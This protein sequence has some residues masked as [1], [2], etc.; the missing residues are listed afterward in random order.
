V[1]ANPVLTNG[2][3]LFN[4]QAVMS[5]QGM[6]RWNAITAEIG[7]W[8]MYAAQ[9]GT[10]I[11]K[12]LVDGIASASSSLK[13]QKR[14]KKAKAPG[15]PVPAPGAPVPAPVVVPDESTGVPTWAIAAGVAVAVAGVV[16]LATRP[17][18][19]KKGA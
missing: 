6:A 1:S 18:N 14:P 16:Y 10:A 11:A 17:D 7:T 5:A 13:T 19:K 2:S 8:Q 12:S 4:D 9:R 15:A 3:L